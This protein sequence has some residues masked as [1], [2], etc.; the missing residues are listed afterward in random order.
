MESNLDSDLYSSIVLKP[1]FKAWAG[2][3]F[4]RICLKHVSQIMSALRIEQLVK[5]YGP[6]FTRRQ[7]G[8]EGVQIDLLIERHDPVTTLCEM[9]FHQG[10]IGTWVIDETEK[11]VALL[12]PQKK[13]IEKILITTGEPSRELL[14]SRYFSTILSHEALF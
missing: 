5:N 14:D 9:K 2:L 1:G 7:P 6:F 12:K 13:T 10:K 3:A 8:Q 4:E 11:K